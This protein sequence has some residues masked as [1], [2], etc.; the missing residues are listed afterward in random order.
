MR[1]G[2]RALIPLFLLALVAPACASGEDR[3]RLR[4][5]GVRP[6][7]LPPGPLNAITDVAGVRVGHRTIVRSQAV[8][9]GVTAILPHGRDLFAEK[10]PAAVYVGNGF[11]KAA[12]FLQVRELGTLETP[13]VLTNTLS[14]GRA[15]EAVVA[16]TLAQEGHEEVRSVNAVVGETNDGYLNDIRGLHVG[17]DDVVAAIEAARAG[18]VAEGSVGAGTGTSAFGW[19]GGIGTSSRR[20]PGPLGG[21]TLGALVQSNFGGVL[22]I[23]GVRVGE[24]LG[25]FSFRDHLTPEPAGAD[26]GGGAGSCMIVLATDAPLSPRNLERLARRAVLGLAR[27][28]GFMSNGSGDFVIAFSTRNLQATADG[29][30][31]IEDLPNDRMSPLFLATVEAVE[32]AVYNSL[33]A[34]RT[35]HGRDGHEREA[36]PIDRLRELLAHRAVGE[37]R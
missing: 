32:E 14:V 21:Y 10:T 33:T 7:V 17:T 18:P 34:A 31:T 8:R 19:K 12:G 37:R 24:A 27:T 36:I 22:T 35:V 16:W 2:I 6:G 13:I 25:R 11:G 15:I 5:L 26:D 30:R 4:D 20:L 3:P 1:H 28:G 9:T 29:P 23:D